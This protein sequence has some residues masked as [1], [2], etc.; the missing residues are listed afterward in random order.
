MKSKKQERSASDDLFRMR[1]VQMLDQR[2]VLY[3][4]AG[5]I[6][7]DVVEERFG[8]LYAEEGRPG[9]PIRLGYTLKGWVGG[10]KRR[11]TV[12]IKRS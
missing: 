5:K 6:D 3:R 1:L 7:W 8:G 2:N 11:V 10:A 12:A 9:I 4:L